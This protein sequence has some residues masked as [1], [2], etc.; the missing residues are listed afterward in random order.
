MLAVLPPPDPPLLPR[1]QWCNVSRGRE[2]TW[3]RR[4]FH[5]MRLWRLLL[6]ESFDI[7]GVDPSRRMLRNPLPALGALRTRD[8]EQYGSGAPPVVIGGTPGWYLKQYY[9]HTVLVA[10]TEAGGRCRSR[11]DQTRLLRRVRVSATKDVHSLHAADEKAAIE[12]GRAHA[13]R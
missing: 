8:D 6:D 4:Q 5:R 7:I 9:L 3:R 11:S 12:G 13:R 2:Y 10:G 1:S